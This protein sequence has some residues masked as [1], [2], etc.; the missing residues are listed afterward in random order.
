MNF[1]TNVKKRRWN[2]AFCDEGS[3]NAGHKLRVAQIKF[4]YCDISCYLHR[5]DMVDRS[6]PLHCSISLESFFTLLPFLLVQLP[7][8]QQNRLLTAI[9]LVS[10]S[11]STPRGRL[12][13]FFTI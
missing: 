1:K 10:F 6:L 3:G 4:F 9:L 8:L 11:A 12:I 7:R 5:V 13:S 2:T